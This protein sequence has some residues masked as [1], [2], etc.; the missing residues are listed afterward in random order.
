MLIFL[1]TVP[2]HPPHT[3]IS[4]VLCL[5]PV[6]HVLHCSP[7]T[8]GEG[9]DFF[10]RSGVAFGGWWT[11]IAAALFA[12]QWGSLSRRPKYETCQGDALSLQHTEQ[13]SAL[14]CVWHYLKMNVAPL[15]CS[16]PEESELEETHS[17]ANSWPAVDADQKRQMGCGNAHVSLLHWYTDVHCSICSVEVK[18]K[19]ISALKQVRAIIWINKRLGNWLTKRGQLAF[20]QSTKRGH[21]ALTLTLTSCFIN[22]NWL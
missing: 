20:C 8:L 15:E 18:Y 6:L 12:L 11:A 16:W 19:L 4:T 7:Y 3:H 1:P 21:L 14:R 17:T 10:I 13:C 2:W 5:P 9:R 22:M